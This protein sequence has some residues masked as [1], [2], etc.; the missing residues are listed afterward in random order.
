MANK[1]YTIVK[2]GEEL[3][4]LKTLPAAK[5]LADAEG[6]EVYTDGQCVYQGKK[7][8]EVEN[9]VTP[10]NTGTEEVVRPVE[11]GKEDPDEQVSLNEEAVR[12][13]QEITRYRLKNL[14]NVRL[15]PSMEAEIKTTKP[16]GTI[17]RAFGIED[18][19]LHLV[20]GTFILFSGGRFA[21]R[22]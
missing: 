17:V 21:E 10:E 14:M 11:D 13:V 9:A 4:K 5:R 1:I 19:W 20:D 2:D 6:A 22:I 3:D 8:E 12:T 7:D 18:D 16:A 15:K